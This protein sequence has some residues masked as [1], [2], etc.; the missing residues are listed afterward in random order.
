MA[1]GL[2]GGREGGAL[3]EMEEDELWITGP[4]Q[5]EGAPLMI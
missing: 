3:V 1:A 4:K 5:E 2:G